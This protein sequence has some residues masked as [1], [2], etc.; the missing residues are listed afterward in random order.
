MDKFFVSIKRTCLVKL[1]FQEI[2]NSLNIM[3]RN[4]FDVLYTLC[5]LL[6]EMAIDIAQAFKQTVIKLF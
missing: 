4:L 3:V 6:V 1:L 5:T 2:F